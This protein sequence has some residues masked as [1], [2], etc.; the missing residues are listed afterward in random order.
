MAELH[1]VHLE[2]REVGGFEW[3]QMKMYVEMAE[4]ECIFKALSW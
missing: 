1:V 2:V 3:E 4:R